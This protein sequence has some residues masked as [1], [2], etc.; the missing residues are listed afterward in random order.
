MVEAAISLAYSPA[1]GRVL[2]AAAM[3]V[4]VATFG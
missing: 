4:R 1:V 3:A 2:D